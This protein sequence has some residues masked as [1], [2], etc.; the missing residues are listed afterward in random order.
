MISGQSLKVEKILRGSLDSI[1]SPSPS[2][3]LQIKGGKVCSRCKGKT[4]LGIVNKL[5][6]T[7]KYVDITKQCFASLPQVDFP[8]NSLNFHW[9]WRWWD[10]IQAIF[11]T[12]FYFNLLTKKLQ[13]GLEKK[14]GTKYRDSVWFISNTV[15]P[16]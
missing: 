10:R 16:R 3:K 7:K 9:R 5:L 15:Q 4:L 11:L 2:V 12:L 8:A 1:P 14:T 6:K 13:Y